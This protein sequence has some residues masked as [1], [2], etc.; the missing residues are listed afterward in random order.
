MSYS[1]T[2]QR[3][4]PQFLMRLKYHAFE[5]LGTLTSTM[6]A[7]TARMEDFEYWLRQFGTLVAIVAG[8]ATIFAV[9]RKEF[10]RKG[11]E[12]PASKNLEK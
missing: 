10:P 8:A 3:P 11:P 9:L 1:T 5:L 2:Y 7:I 6:G 12:S 4:Q